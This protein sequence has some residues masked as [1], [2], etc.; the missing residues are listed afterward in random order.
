MLL[1]KD[2][3]TLAKEESI[4]IYNGKGHQKVTGTRPPFYV[5]KDRFKDPAFVQ[6]M[7]KKIINEYAIAMTFSLP[8]SPIMSL[9][10]SEHY[11]FELPPPDSKELPV[12]RY[13]FWDVVGDFSG[14]GLP[15]VPTLEQLKSGY[16]KNTYFRPID[17]LANGVA[18]AIVEIAREEIKK[19]GV[20]GSDYYSETLKD[21]KL[22]L[23]DDNF[24][25]KAL[26]CARQ[27]AVNFLKEQLRE[28]EVKT[29][30]LQNNKAFLKFILSAIS[31]ADLDLVKHILELHPNPSAFI[32]EHFKIILESAT[33]YKHQTIIDY[34][35]IT[36]PA[37]LHD[38]DV[39]SSHSMTLASVSALNASPPA[40]VLSAVTSVVSLPNVSPRSFSENKQK[41]DEKKSNVNRKDGIGPTLTHN[42]EFAADHDGTDKLVKKRMQAAQ[43][44]AAIKT[45]NS[46]E[47]K[48]HPVMLDR[49]YNQMIETIRVLQGYVQ[50]QITRL[51]PHKNDFFNK[52][53]I[54][55]TRLFELMG[56][57][58]T[59]MQED[60]TNQDADIG[61][62]NKKTEQYAQ[63]LD[64]CIADCGTIAH[65]HRRSK[66]DRCANFFIAAI[67]KV[68]PIVPPSWEEWQHLGK[69]LLQAAF[70][71][72]E[73]PFY[74]AYTHSLDEKIRPKDNY[75][76]YR[77]ETFR[78]KSF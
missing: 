31:T 25:N 30:I 24:L 72:Q 58:L 2:F 39:A 7:L 52:G 69:A 48:T 19:E 26:V 3:E 5:L 40:A 60:M 70:Q 10:D 36:L 33:Q 22:A 13:M 21:I 62:L 38:G 29:F 63:D 74:R 56:E 53:I 18:V 68:K 11:C 45:P 66:L 6:Q 46:K 44:Q 1:T 47:E 4:V 27:E 55:K 14:V 15:L 67:P 50:A 37:N 76:N 51:S 73:D 23:N 57:R 28:P 43:E 17:T 16:D 49:A 71:Q 77:H 65:H 41:N 20:T 61:I 35:S 75:N 64:K 78:R 34:L 8:I 32:K 9:D 59:K 42:D 54:D 12:A